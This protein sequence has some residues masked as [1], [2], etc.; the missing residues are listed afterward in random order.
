M[1]E[2]YD[3]IIKNQ[4]TSNSIERVEE[5][6]NLPITSHHAVKKD[7]VTTPIRVIFSC[8]SWAVKEA[9]SLNDCLYTK[10]NLSENLLDVLVKFRLK[11]YALV[12][13]ISKAFLRIVLKEENRDFMKFL[14]LRDP[15][16]E[17]SP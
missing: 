13:D 6:V 17:N 1:V 9:S 7:S 2:Q 8:S 10:P 16:E 12:A 11:P 14:W 4:T 15:S 3:D 5:P